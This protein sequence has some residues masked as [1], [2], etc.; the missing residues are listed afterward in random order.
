MESSPD[1]LWTVHLPIQGS[2][3]LKIGK[4][5]LKMRKQLGFQVGGH[6]SIFISSETAWRNH[7][8]P[9]ALCLHIKGATSVGEDS[10]KPCDGK[11]ETPYFHGA[12]FEEH[13]TVIISLDI[14]LVL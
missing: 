14:I 11:A 13:M 10:N 1:A 4:L 5:K 9:T 3:C 2:P 7:I 12:Y 6:V 8:F